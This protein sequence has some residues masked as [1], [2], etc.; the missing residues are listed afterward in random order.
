MS[1]LAR[2]AMYNATIRSIV[3]RNEMTITLGDGREKRLETT[4]YLLRPKSSFYLP[5]CTGMKTGFTNASGKCLVSSATHRGRSVICVLLGAYS[6]G[7]KSP[8][9]M[10][11]RES[12]ALL[13][14]ALGVN[15]P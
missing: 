5:L 13:Q 3:G 12:R 1:R 2:A 9:V 8:S 14:W 7:G 11:W 4:N 10:A 15:T 6:K